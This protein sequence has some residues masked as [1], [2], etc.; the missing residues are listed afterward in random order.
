[1]R[2]LAFLGFLAVCGLLGFFATMFSLF[3]VLAHAWAV[4]AL[5]LVAY[6]FRRQIEGLVLRAAGIDPIRLDEGERE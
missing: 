6:L 3:E 5:L 1:M 4:A 2:F